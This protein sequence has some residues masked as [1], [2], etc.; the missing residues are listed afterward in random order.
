MAHPQYH[1]RPL[2]APPAAIRAIWHRA[3]TPLALRSWPLRSCRSSSSLF[4]V[5][6]C[7]GLDMGRSILCIAACALLTPAYG[8]VAGPAPL[9][10][11]MFRSLRS[12]IFDV[13]VDAKVNRS[14]CAREADRCLDLCDLLDDLITKLIVGPST[15]DLSDFT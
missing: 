5:A 6:L 15:Q 13:R 11:R 10:S 3:S 2:A 1:P 4:S 9:P 8:Q 7:E 14:R 12:D